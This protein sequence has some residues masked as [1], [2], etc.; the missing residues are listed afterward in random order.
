MSP[1]HGKG[2]RPP[3]PGRVIQVKLPTA[4]LAAIDADAGREGVTRAA[5]IRQACELRLEPARI[6]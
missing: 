4:L 3:L 5:W 6:P 2:G 1:A